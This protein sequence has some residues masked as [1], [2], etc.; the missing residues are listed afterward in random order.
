MDMNHTADETVKMDMDQSHICGT[1]KRWTSSGA[2]TRSGK[3]PGK[4]KRLLKTA[5]P[6]AGKGQ[7]HSNYGVPG[8]TSPA[9]IDPHHRNP[10]R[11]WRPF[12]CCSLRRYRRGR[13]VSK[14]RKS[15]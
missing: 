7:I 11:W 9:Y 1:V 13:A 14:E 8:A 12:F 15:G 10:H 2:H 3:R 6:S 4:G 5:R